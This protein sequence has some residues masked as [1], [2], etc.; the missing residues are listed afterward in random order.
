MLSRKRL[1]GLI[2]VASSGEPP[3]C[4]AAFHSTRISCPC[5]PQLCSKPMG[6]EQYKLNWVSCGWCPATQT[7]YLYSSQRWHTEWFYQINGL[8]YLIFQGCLIAARTS[9]ESK[10][11]FDPQQ[12]WCAYSS[13]GCLDK[14]ELGTSKYPFNLQ[15]CFVDLKYFKM[16]SLGTKC[17]Y[18]GL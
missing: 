18:L 4:S 14:K 15:W 3:A 6:V 11:E 12:H 8:D 5:L 17:R 7:K 9:P 13:S 1:H 16:Y 10:A 2:K